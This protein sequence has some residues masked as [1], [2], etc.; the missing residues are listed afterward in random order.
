MKTTLSTL[1]L[2]PDVAKV[3]SLINQ[4]VPLEYKD[5]FGTIRPVLLRVIS[6]EQITAGDTSIL[7]DD[8]QL[9]RSPRQLRAIVGRCV[10]G[11][12]GYGSDSAPVFLDPEVRA[13]LQEVN[14]QW[15]HWPFT[16]CGFFPSAAAIALACI[17]PISAV[18]CEGSVTITYET[19]AME[20]FFLSSLKSAAALDRRAET[21]PRQALWR[22]CIFRSGLGLFE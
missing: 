16:C 8:F 5:G 7:L 6:R 12:G 1:T 20:A 21:P 4:G 19:A 15:P 17:E 2:P 9:T 3:E 22:L 18:Q 11:L 10:F 14:S 13:Y